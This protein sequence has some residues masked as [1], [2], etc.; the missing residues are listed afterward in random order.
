MGNDEWAIGNRKL[1][2]IILKSIN[3]KNP[4]SDNAKKLF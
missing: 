1:K 4:N 3:H 2:I